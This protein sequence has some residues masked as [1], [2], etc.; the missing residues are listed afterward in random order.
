MENKSN[1]NIELQKM[2]HE[3][4]QGGGKP[5]RIG[6]IPDERQDLNRQIDIL[7]LPPRNEVHKQKKRTKISVS[8]A[9]ARFLFVILIFLVLIIGSYYLWGDE[10]IFLLKK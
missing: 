1:E 4:E 3:V 2:L 10:L 7:N 9:L 6:K 5:P 8:A